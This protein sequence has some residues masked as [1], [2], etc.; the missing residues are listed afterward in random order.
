MYCF[1]ISNTRG[2]SPSCENCNKY[3][4]DKDGKNEIKFAD[5][6]IAKLTKTD[7]DNKSLQTGDNSHMALCFALCQRWC[8]D[9]HRY[10]REKEKG[11]C[12]IKFN[13][14]NGHI[15]NY[16]SSSEIYAVNLP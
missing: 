5:T 8:V 14:V 2:N 6:V 7:D 15:R 13:K 4:S 12:K 16:P 1:L 3:F 11:F 10:L 9:W